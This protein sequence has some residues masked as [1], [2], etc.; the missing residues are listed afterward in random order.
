MCTSAT[1]DLSLF[2][3]PLA[4]RSR[5][6]VLRSISITLIYAFTW[7]HLNIRFAYSKWQ[8][9]SIC[10]EISNIHSMSLYSI[11]Q[12]QM[13]NFMVFFSFENLNIFAQIYKI[14]LRWWFVIDIQK[15]KTKIAY[16]LQNFAISWGRDL[17]HRA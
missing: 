13:K 2:H 11:V 15:K 17:R 16:E 14:S 4:L 12:F 8:I 9:Y 7:I 10:Y 5:V 3:S 6:I 1:S